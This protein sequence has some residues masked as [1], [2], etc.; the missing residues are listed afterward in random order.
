M[1]SEQ[2]Q[3]A[4]QLENK[5]EQ[6]EGPFNYIKGN[7]KSNEII[8][9]QCGIGKVNAAAGTVE[10]IRNMVH[11]AM[12]KGGNVREEVQTILALT[13]ARSAAIVYGQVLSEEEMANLVDSL[14]ACPTPG[15][16][17]D[18]KTVLINFEKIESS[19]QVRICDFMNGACYVLDGSVKQITNKMVLYVPKGIAIEK[20]E[21]N[22]A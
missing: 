10:L 14:F 3:L 6:T 17:P 5:T 4:N 15:Y 11:T 2:R 19:E 9:M 22:K 7:I 21:A 12:E 20:I 18:G 8:L 1:S 16:T 13:L